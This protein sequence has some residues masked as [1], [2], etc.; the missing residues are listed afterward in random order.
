MNR[1]APFRVAFAL[2]ACVNVGWGFFDSPPAVSFLDARARLQLRGTIDTEAYWFDRPAPGLIFTPEDGLVNPRAA[3]FLDAQ[4]GNH[5]YIFV[6]TRI[7]RGFDPAKQDLECRLDEYALR[8]TPGKDGRF[9]IQLGKFATIVGSWAAR[10][11]SWENP[12]ITAPVVYENV[13]AVWDAQAAP[14]V[15]TLLRWAFVRPQGT[16]QL[17]YA[18]KHLR[19]PVIWGPSYTA[20]AVVAGK[21]GKIEYATE[22]K[23]QSLASRPEHWAP[24]N[25]P[26]S[27]PT[28]SGRLAWHPTPTWTFGASSSCGSYLP[29]DARGPLAE[30][31][32]LD[33][34]RQFV[35]GQEIGFAWRHWQVWFEAFQ[36]RFE[37][38]EVADLDVL[39]WYIET[40]YKFT[41]QFFGA[42]RWNEQIFDHVT[43]SQGNRVRWGRTLRRLDL[44]PGYRFSAYTQLKLQVS[45]QH[46]ESAPDS[47]SPLAALQFTLRF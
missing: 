7:D 40:K 31:H 34:Y 2:T 5:L 17:E 37:I 18:D 9:N 8:Y 26:W 33:D 14:S 41:P 42:L 46:E 16:P 23:N 43:D 45:L 35:V 6:Q 24:D 15:N 10:H 12:F 1:L 29:A 36:A 20:G 13:T 21:L 11:G 25:K 39:S 38:P 3:L 44:A 47:W 28:V 22:I 19:L 27:S 4:I 32:D 30:G